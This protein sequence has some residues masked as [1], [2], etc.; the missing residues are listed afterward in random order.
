MMGNDG[1]V[2]GADAALLGAATACAVSG[3]CGSEPPPPPPPPAG[4]TTPPTVAV[5]APAAGATVIGQVVVAASASDNVD[6]TGVQFQIN[7]A[8]LGN[9]VTSSPYS[10][11]W[12]TTL[13]F[14][15]GSYTVTAIARDA[16]GNTTSSSP[17][18][19]TVNNVVV[20]PP[21]T[22]TAPTFS[23]VFTS[24]VQTNYAI[25]N[26][27]TSQPGTSQV[28][29][30][31]TTAYGNATPQHNGLVSVHDTPIFNLTPG[32][33]YHFRLKSMN[34]AGLLGVS[35]DFTF[36]TAGTPPPPPEPV[37]GVCGPWSEW[38]AWT[39][40]SSTTESR[41]RTRVQVQPPSNGGEPC[42]P[43]TETETRLIQLPT[44][45]GPTFSNVFTS[46]VTTNYAIVNYTTSEPGTSQVE[47]GTTTAYGNATPMHTGLVT[48]HD[49]PLFNLTPGVTYHYRVKSMNAAGQLGVSADFTFT[50][51]GTAPSPLTIS[52]VTVTRVNSSTYRVTWQ[53]SV[54]S[55]SQVQYGTTT[56]YGSQSALDSQMVTSHSVTL[57]GLTAGTTY[58]YRVISKDATGVTKASG[59]FTFTARRWWF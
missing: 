29:Y 13:G 3:Q 30:G 50:T 40:I 20:P 34:S 9:E 18:S 52:G 41:T 16:A 1:K 53:T 28:E 4:D 21:P 38:S 11:S 44:G 56:A 47:Y 27:T 10:A 25:V 19:V 37:D 54:A 26:Y 23:N 7:G 48:V 57:S 24:G 42:S 14:P 31:T 58:H 33:T 51:S 32:T 8:D 43:L 45:T 55:T 36:T 39:A 5:T 2:I 17:V 49:T 12:T 46:G 15:N 22:G 59:D 35:G 6:V